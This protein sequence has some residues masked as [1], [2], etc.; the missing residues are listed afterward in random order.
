[1]TCRRRKVRCNKQSPCSNCIKSGV[2]CVFPLSRQ[3]SRKSRRPADEEVLSRLR[4]LED[5]IE[6]LRGKNAEAGSTPSLSSAQ[7]APLSTTSSTAATEASAAT[8]CKPAEPQKA[9]DRV[10]AFADSDPKKASSQKFE[11]EFGRLVIDESR[12]RYVS[13]LLWASLGNEV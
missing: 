13:N 11:N 3:A 7:A 8:T 10:C 12:S 9:V 2:E 5:V 4:H 1:M 6:H